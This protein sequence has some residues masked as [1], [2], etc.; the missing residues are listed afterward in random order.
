MERSRAVHI[1]THGR[2]NVD[3]A[4][5]Q[6]LF[7]APSEDSD[8]RLHAYEMLD[9]DLRG[10]DLVTL[11][12][13]ETA[14]G[15]FDSADNLRG[16]PAMMMLSGV[17][18]IIGTLWDVETTVS[19]FFFTTLYQ[20][21]REDQGRLDAFATAQRETRARHPQYRDWGAFYFTGDWLS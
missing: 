12:A 1:A 10:L 8:G 14:L 20:A 9:F 19:E 21:L 13:C 11:S 17:A 2:H 7:V 18:S 15:R 6:S 16:L 5:F 4:A 3:A